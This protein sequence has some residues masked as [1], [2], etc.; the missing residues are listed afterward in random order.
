MGFLMNMNMKRRRDSGNS[1]GDVSIWGAR[2]F[3]AGGGVVDLWRNNG[4][5]ALEQIS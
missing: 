4:M 2:W 1:V 5:R 3:Y